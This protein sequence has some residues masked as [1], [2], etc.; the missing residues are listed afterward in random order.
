MPSILFSVVSH[1]QGELISELLFD[2]NNIDL[3]H[4]DEVEIVITLNIPE[5]ETFLAKSNRSLKVIRNLR[6]IGYGSNHNQAFA[7]SKSDY[8]VVL[9]P[10]VRISGILISKFI[11][12]GPTSWGCLAPKV[13]SKDGT[14]EDNARKYPTIGRILKRV[15]FRRGVPDYSKLSSELIPVDWVAG[16]FILFPSNVFRDVGGFD[17]GYFMYL[18]D[19]DICK[20]I[21]NQ[22]YEVFY[23]LSQSIVHDARRS[24]FKSFIHFKWHIRSMIRFLFK[25]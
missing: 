24:S 18:E 22:G 20:R 13:F 23:D 15:L 12:N 25:V 7:M 17:N 8:F 3:C 16:M 2:L 9:N 5:D 1:G 14:L 10:D 4:F 6:P 11:E 19:A 21:R